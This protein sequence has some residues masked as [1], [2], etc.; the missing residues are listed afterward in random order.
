GCQDIA[1]DVAGGIAEHDLTAAEA[2]SLCHVIEA[3]GTK[4]NVPLL[5]AMLPCYLAF[6]LGMWSTASGTAACDMADRYARK[7]SQ[8]FSERPG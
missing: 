1:W 8:C 6:Q 7:L 3:S 2:A 5:G 4:V